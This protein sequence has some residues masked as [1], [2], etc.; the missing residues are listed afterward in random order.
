MRLGRQR[1]GSSRRRKKPRKLED[2]GT[3]ELE[4]RTRISIKSWF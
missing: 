4:S 3:A 1:S 2:G